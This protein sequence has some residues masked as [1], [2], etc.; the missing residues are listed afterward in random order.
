MRP[1]A[2]AVV[3]VTVWQLAGGNQVDWTGTSMQREQQW[4]QSA[5]QKLLG[6]GTRLI[7]IACFKKSTCHRPDDA[8]V[9]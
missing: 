5:S 2:G 3:W 4:Q 9:G 6:I 1:L 7:Q 8:N